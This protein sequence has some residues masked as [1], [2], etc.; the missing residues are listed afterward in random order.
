MTE[1]EQL[2]AEIKRRLNS[3]RDMKAEHDQIR[4]ELLALEILMGSPSGPNLDGMPRSSGVSNPVANQAIKHITLEQRYKAQLARLAAAQEQIEDTIDAL[5]P[6]ERRLARF[7]YIDGLTWEKVCE[8]MCYS[9]MQTH[10]I[11]GR[12]LDK[13][14][15]AELE[16]RSAE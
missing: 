2:R 1:R 15:N 4:D 6:T 7:R 3:Y 9:W 16:K 8:R 13:L 12:M 11:H 5:E 10:R 14:V